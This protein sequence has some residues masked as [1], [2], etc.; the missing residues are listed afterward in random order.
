MN[1]TFIIHRSFPC[2]YVFAVVVVSSMVA[3]PFGRF[4]VPI[5]ILVDVNVSLIVSSVSKKNS[6]HDQP[7][8]PCSSQT[9]RLFQDTSMIYRT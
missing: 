6:F 8:T 9:T 4:S 3:Q 1:S 5:I 2:L 7:T